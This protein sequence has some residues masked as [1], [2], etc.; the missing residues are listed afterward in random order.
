MKSIFT[1]EV[2][3]WWPRVFFTYEEALQHKK[4]LDGAGYFQGRVHE[5]VKK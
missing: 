3:G 1:V 4:A 2:E 5:Y